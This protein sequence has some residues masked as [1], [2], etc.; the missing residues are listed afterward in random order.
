MIPCLYLARSPVRFACSYTRLSPSNY[1]FLFQF[2][3]FNM[4]VDAS[5]Y[6]PLTDAAY[7]APAVKQPTTRPMNTS[8]KPWRETPL[9]ESA[10]LS[11]AAGWYGSYP[12]LVPPPFEASVQ[13]NENSHASKAYLNGERSPWCVDARRYQ[14]RTSRDTNAQPHHQIPHQPS[15]TPTPSQDSAH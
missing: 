4:T 14:Q 10:N 8:K 12:F 2:H 7:R 9:V 5:I 3:S 13:I 15:L 1:T 6:A 11:E